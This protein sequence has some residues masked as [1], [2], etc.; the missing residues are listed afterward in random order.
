MRSYLFLP[1]FA[2][3]LVLL[4][5]PSS[6]I[7][8]GSLADMESESSAE[9]QVVTLTDSG[10]ELP[11]FDMTQCNDAACFADNV[12]VDTSCPSSTMGSQE[13]TSRA[14]QP[15]APQD[16]ASNC[17]HTTST[18]ERTACGVS[19]APEGIPGS[20]IVR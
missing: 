11:T 14:S 16:F 19:I 1:S 20:I 17:V 8:E 3:C 15:I 4:Y 12:G 2:L 13:H 10:I 6:G 9:S 7:S 18:H 5:M